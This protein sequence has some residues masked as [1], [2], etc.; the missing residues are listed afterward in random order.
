M[1]QSFLNKTLL[2]KSILSMIGHR[3][4]YYMVKHRLQSVPIELCFSYVSDHQKFPFFLVF[5]RFPKFKYEVKVEILHEN[6][7]FDV[8]K[9]R[10]EKFSP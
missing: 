3:T 5:V 4:T 10:S 2:F 1:L 8:K 7:R 6:M 9:Q